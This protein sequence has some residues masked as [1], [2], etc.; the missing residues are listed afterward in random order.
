MAAHSSSIAAQGEVVHHHHHWSSAT[1]WWEQPLFQ[2]HKV[3]DKLELSKMLKTPF[4][5]IDWVLS[6]LQKPV[7]PFSL[8]L[9]KFYMQNTCW[10]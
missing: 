9:P 6:H 10:R 3:P 4:G 7:N 8:S 1:A 5:S 2:I